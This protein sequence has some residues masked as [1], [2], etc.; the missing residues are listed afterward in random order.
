[1]K[2][3]R[4]SVQGGANSRSHLRRCCGA[5]DRHL[6][7]HAMSGENVPYSTMKVFFEGDLRGIKPFMGLKR[8]PECLQADG[9]IKGMSK[10]EI[11]IYLGLSN[12]DN[13]LQN[14]VGL[15]LWDTQGPLGMDLYVFVR[16]GWEV[17]GRIMKT[18]RI[19]LWVAALEEVNEAEVPGDDRYV[20]E[21]NGKKYMPVDK[22]CPLFYINEEDT[23]YSLGVAQLFDEY[24]QYYS[25]MQNRVDL[26][27]LETPQGC[28][29]LL[30]WAPSLGKHLCGGEASYDH[31][32]NQ[33]RLEAGLYNL[34]TSYGTSFHKKGNSETGGC[35]LCP[36]CPATEPLTEEDLVVVHQQF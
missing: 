8:V 34:R 16:K 20:W 12:Y 13:H 10:K 3:G 11:A 30:V 15:A 17:Q 4:G 18:L 33:I 9:S 14:G 24:E 21:S 1:M 32:S 19:L 22:D 28:F 5:P 2:R 29:L 6:A 36:P 26:T 31:T 27:F 35:L 7:L 23:L 25:T